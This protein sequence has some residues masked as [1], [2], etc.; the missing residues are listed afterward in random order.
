MGGGGTADVV[1]WTGSMCEPTGSVSAPVRASACDPRV[2]LVDVFLHLNALYVITT[3]GGREGGKWGGFGSCVTD[4][5][6]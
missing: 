2:S 3:G 5:Q 6:S 1:Q 4:H